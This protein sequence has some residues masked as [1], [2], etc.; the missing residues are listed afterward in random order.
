MKVDGVVFERVYLNAN[1]NLSNFFVRYGDTFIVG[2]HNK[3][4]SKRIWNCIKTFLSVRGLQINFIKS[5]IQNWKEGSKFN[6]LGFTFYFIFSSVSNRFLQQSTVLKNNIRGVYISPSNKS[7]KDLKLVIKIKTSRKEINKSPSNLIEQLNPIIFGW[8]N[9]FCIGTKKIFSKFDYYIGVRTWK[10]LRRKYQ[11]VSARY[12]WKKYYKISMI[13]ENRR[14]CWNFHS[15]FNKTSNDLVNSKK[16]INWLLSFSKFNTELPSHMFRIS[17][18]ML[19]TS[20]YLKTKLFIDWYIKSFDLK[21][22]NG[23][24]NNWNELYKIQNGV[25]AK[26]LQPLGYLSIENLKIY[27]KIQTFNPQIIRKDLRTISL[28]HKNCQWSIPVLK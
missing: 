28:I 4:E 23:F 10:F 2:T 19:E 25:C 8:G 5:K 14:N 7:I 15:T 20:Y 3:M 27:S 11:K 6:Y 1:K 26:C 9:Y 16:K 12:L 13:N 21:S 17:Q 18:Q 22:V 24:T